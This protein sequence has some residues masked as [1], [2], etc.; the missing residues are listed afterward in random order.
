MLPSLAATLNG[1]RRERGRG[2]EVRAEGLV[3]AAV[4]R[5]PLMFSPQHCTVPSVRRTQVVSSPTVTCCGQA[6]ADHRGGTRLLLASPE[7]P[8]RARR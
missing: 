3:E 6:L 8:C 4:P 5:A 7:G 1:V 2:R